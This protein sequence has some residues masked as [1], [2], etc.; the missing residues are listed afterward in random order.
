MQSVIKRSQSIIFS[1]I[2]NYGLENFSLSILEYCLEEERFEREEYYINMLR[3]QYNILQK[4]GSSSGYKHS[5][6]T[7][8]KMRGRLRPS[9]SMKIEVLDLHTNEKSYYDSLLIASK[10]LNVHQATVSNYFSRNQKTAY[11]GRYIFKKVES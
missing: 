1:A 9:L 7:L 2:L 11:K 4:A 6:E 5:E 3:P 8:K 10:A